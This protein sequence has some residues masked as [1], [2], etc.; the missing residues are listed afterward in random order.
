MRILITLALGALLVTLTACV[1]VDPATGE[2]LPQP[3][4]VGMASLPF[5]IF[6]AGGL[7][8]YLMFGNR[9]RTYSTSFL[10]GVSMLVG[11]V[12]WLAL[13]FGS[14][15]VGFIVTKGALHTGEA[16]GT[17]F[18]GVLFTLALF[19]GIPTIIGVAVWKLLLVIRRAAPNHKA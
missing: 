2:R 5:L 18:G 19:G 10:F 1:A 15:N 3:L 14:T 7:G 13:L 16:V 17:I 8:I 9:S 12:V 4:Q 6:I 11:A